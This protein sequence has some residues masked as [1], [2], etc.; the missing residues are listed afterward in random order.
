MSDFDNPILIVG[1]EI[2]EPQGIIA[3]ERHQ[4]CDMC[5]E[6]GE[7]RP[8]GPNGESICFPCGNKD[9]EATE[10]MMAKVMFGIT[11]ATE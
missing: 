6:V 4:Q 11:E 7:L 3:A 9:P 2:I 10:R 5:G 1:N 8:Y